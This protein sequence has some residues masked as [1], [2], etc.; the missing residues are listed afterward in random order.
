MQ[1]FEKI[2]NRTRIKE[3]LHAINEWTVENS[4]LLD[5]P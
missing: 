1:M 3:G 4:S 2:G 5:M